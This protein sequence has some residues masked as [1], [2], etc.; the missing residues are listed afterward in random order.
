MLLLLLVLL[1]PCPRCH[2]APQCLQGHRS[3]EHALC[4]SEVDHHLH[5]L[6]TAGRHR[7]H[8][9]CHL[10]SREG[11][12]V[13]VRAVVVA[14]VGHAMEVAAEGHAVDVDPQTPV[15]FAAAAAHAA[16]AVDVE[17]LK[18]VMDPVH[19]GQVQCVLL[20]AVVVHFVQGVLRE[21]G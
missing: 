19:N 18:Q 2:K 13:A 15:A 9:C 21:I 5:Y 3:R 10:H 1:L 6:L 14:A 7:C 20:V 17:L 8:C 11:V 12:A 4:A 16:H